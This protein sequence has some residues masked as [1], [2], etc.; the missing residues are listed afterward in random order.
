MPSPLHTLF[1]RALAWMHPR[2]AAV[3]RQ[4]L[5]AFIASAL[6]DA[7]TT[8]RARAVG[9][10][11]INLT[12]DLARAWI[13]RSALPITAR[14][15]ATHA[16]ASRRSSSMDRLASDL[17]Y[18]IRVLLRT[19]LFT[20]VAVAVLAIGIGASTA[21]YAVVDGVLLR[22]F[23]YPDMHRLAILN[24]RGGNGQMMSVAWPTYLDWRAQNEVFEELGIYRSTVVTLTGGQ[25]P[26]RLNASMTSS[27]VFTSMGIQPLAGRVFGEAED[28]V[29]TA[30][31]AVISERLWRNRFAAREDIV[32]LGVT[33]NAEPFTIVGVMPTGMRFPSRMTDVWI[34]LGLFINGFP[35]SRGAHPGLTA[36]GRVKP[37]LSFDQARAGMDTVARRLGE[38]Y[39]DTNKNLTVVVSSYYE[40]IVQNIRPT[41]YLLLGA[42]S[43]LLVMACTNLASLMLARAEGRHR[44]FAVRAALGA[45]RTRLVRQ[46]LVEASLLAVAGG[47]AG[48]ALAHAIVQAFI[49]MRPTTIPRIDLLAVDWRVS[50]FAIGLSAFTAIVVGLLPAI[51]AARPDLQRHLRDVRS[52]GSRRAVNL[53]RVLVVGQVAVAAV[54]LIGAGLLGKSLARLSAI[55]LGFEPSQLLTMRL[56]IPNAAY[57]SADAWIAF[58]KDVVERLT[59]LH[60]ADAVGVN[61]A[62][63]L[64]GGGSESPV[65]KE[66][67]PMPGPGRVETMCLFQSSGGEYFRAMGIELKRGRFF[68]SRDM[69]GAPVAVIDETAA[70]K[71]FG[72]ENPVGRR[73]AFEFD[74]AEN[75]HLPGSM[76]PKWREVVGVVGTVKHYGL[77]SGPP[78][79]QIYAPFTQLP[80]WFRDRRPTMA[81]VVRTTGDAD[82]MIASV[83][84]TVAA[85]DARV[86]VFGV[87]PMTQYIGQQTEQ[88]RLSALLMTGFGVLAALVAT[89]GLY[90]VLAYI[91]SQRTREI[92]VRLAL[93]ARR[94][95]IVRQVVRS[96]LILA[97]VGLV[98][99]LGTA[100]GAVRWIATLLYQVS[101]T[102]G[103]TFVWVAAGLLVTALLAS[104]L[105]ARRASRVDPLVAL[106]SD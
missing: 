22:P 53:R 14:R 20:T 36:V 21:V 91:V 73:I 9:G 82:S 49:A 83:R 89:I 95:D 47:I 39:P 42:V 98:V 10:L 79:V 35:P 15:L 94:T 43:L 2:R 37:G 63:P 106:R 84:R 88:P 96:G 97:I 17:R 69:A 92:G 1:G 87:Q 62:L 99:G 11:L 72:A 59:A 55:E 5:S 74:G 28:Q 64:E 23:T 93:G 58:H 26:E 30:R 33:F 44:E 103:T 81:L 54:L 61:S 27:S 25:E 80:I 50:L 85:V 68:E 102:D 90:G 18:A 51:R 52:S 78:Y 105:P 24:E 71:L 12:G 41:L 16:P 100:I 70:A 7:W 3:D 13:G 8:G 32:G 31:V 56:S 45:A 38:T 76:T 46:V 19:P 34:P 101:P 29:G 75:A 104:L 40:Q 57:P 6:G 4:E 65:I 67:D 48:V 77:I 66:G 60:G 86:P